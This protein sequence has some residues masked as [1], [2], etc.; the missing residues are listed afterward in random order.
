MPSIPAAASL[1]IVEEMVPHEPATDSP[2][3]R[4]K[5]SYRTNFLVRR[6]IQ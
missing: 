2:G 4:K 5:R 1:G 6:Q 3:F